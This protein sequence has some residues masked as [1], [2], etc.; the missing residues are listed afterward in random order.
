MCGVEWYVL[1]ESL[2]FFF[3]LADIAGHGRWSLPSETWTSPGKTLR[4]VP[5]WGFQADGN[6][7]SA[8]VASKEADAAVW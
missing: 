6:A 1:L 3:F 4:C 7:R 2:T 8:F 5:S